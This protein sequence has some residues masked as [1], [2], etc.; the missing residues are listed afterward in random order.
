MKHPRHPNQHF[1]STVKAVR[2]LLRPLLDSADVTDTS[3]EMNASTAPGF[4]DAQATFVGI[5]TSQDESRFH[6]SV[7]LARNFSAIDNVDDRRLVLALTDLLSRRDEPA[8]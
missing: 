6:E 2:E 4:S 7:R 1:D 5:Q 8:S 3:S